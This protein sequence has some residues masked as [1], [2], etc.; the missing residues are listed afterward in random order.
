MENPLVVPANCAILIPMMQIEPEIIQ[1]VKN[2]KNSD[3]LMDFE[4]KF[5]HSENAKISDLLWLCSSMF[6]SCG[7][8]INVPQ[9]MWFTND[10]YPHAPNS[11]EFNQAFQKAK[12]LQQ[13]QLDVQ[14]HPMKMD[15]DGELFYKEL[16]CQLLNYDIDEY[17]FPTPQL[18]ENLLLKRT[19]R[20]GYDK[21]SLAYLNVELSPNAK[22]G[23]GIYSFTRSA[24]Y[25]RPIMMTRNSLEQVNTKRFHKF[26]K[27]PEDADGT[28]DLTANIEH[29]FDYSEKLEPSMTV[30]YLPCG[31]ENIKFTPLEAYEIKQVMDPKIKVL[32]FKPLS[33]LNELNHFK[34]SYFIYPNESRVKNSKVFFRAL[35]E[36]CL[37]D[38]KI[39]ICTCT[40]RLKSHPRLVALVPTQ[41]DSS[42]DGETQHYDGFRMYF[43][44]F[45]GDIRDLSEVLKE[46]PPVD[47]DFSA[48]M[49][50][51]I[52]RLR[53]NYNSSMFENP[54]L[55]QLYTK[56][57]EKVY[58]E[59]AD[60]E[61]RVDATLP[62]LDA[63][64]DRIEQFVDKLSQLM[65]G[66]E[67]GKTAS[68]RNAPEASGDLK[69]KKV[70]ADDVNQV[71]K[72][73]INQI[74]LTLFLNL[75][76]NLC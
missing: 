66:F 31:G 58:D 16:L 51:I 26:G 42:P 6:S 75:F 34:P 60:D 7:K 45:A 8:Q 74:Y 29:D 46:S 48:A 18:N 52:S 21:R 13:L 41:Q 15:F 4:D 19:F 5:C 72:T 49:K 24:S 30:K 23:V 10:D 57:E 65:D 53:I 36:R 9:I 54:I 33:V 32:G 59:E 43:I 1:Y 64:N 62:N 61:M 40:Q 69:K 67:E 50:K 56:I 27:L 73:S 17:Q 55:K 14:F 22:F 44:P 76:R 38:E 68:K 63:Q 35:W 28:V 20:K 11:N 2:V 71:S 70:T 12:D 47:Q 37:A 25:P 3:D 39:I